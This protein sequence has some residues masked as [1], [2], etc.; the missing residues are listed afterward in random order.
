[1]IEVR[2]PEAADTQAF[3]GRLAS[4]VR[5]GDVIVLAG[6][7]GSGK[8][9]FTSGLAAGLGVEEAVVSPSFVLVRQYQS[10]FMPLVHV[11]VYRLGSLNEFD[12]LDVFELAEEGVLVIEWGDAVQSTLPDDH[13]RVDFSVGDDDERTLRLISSGSWS[14]RDLGEVV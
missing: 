13:L 12:D 2:C 14:Q 8:T 4:I 9:L 7:L 10:G 1:L 3:A 5:P 11:D 6:G